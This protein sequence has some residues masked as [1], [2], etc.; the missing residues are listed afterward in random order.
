MVCHGTNLN[1]NIIMSPIMWARY[2]SDFKIKKINC[3]IAS[4]LINLTY[5][6]PVLTKIL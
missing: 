6:Y 4:N 5:R 3:P 1:D 2:A